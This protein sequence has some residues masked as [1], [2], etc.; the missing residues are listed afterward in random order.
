MVISRPW[1][2]LVSPLMTLSLWTHR[3]HHQL[4]DQRWLA[5]SGSGWQLWS[6]T[7]QQAKLLYSSGNSFSHNDAASILSTTT[8]K[9]VFWVCIFRHLST[10]DDRIYLWHQRL[11]RDRNWTEIF[12]SCLIC[13]LINFANNRNSQ[14]EW[15]YSLQYLK[16]W[17]SSDSVSPLWAWLVIR[18]V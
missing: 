5:D 16:R 8:T 15:D 13:Y 12:K 11:E 3:L 9:V 10:V 18:R 17:M 2:V 4:R 6:F 14:F 7:W 1:Q